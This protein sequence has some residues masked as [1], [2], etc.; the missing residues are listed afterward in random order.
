MKTTEHMVI[1]Y[2]LCN[3]ATETNTAWSIPPV[4]S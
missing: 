1:S 3:L 2:L 4:D